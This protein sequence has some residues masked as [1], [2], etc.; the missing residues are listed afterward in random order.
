MLSPG[1]LLLA[2]ACSYQL[3][4]QISEKVASRVCMNRVKNVCHLSHFESHNFVWHCTALI[5]IKC[6][7]LHVNQTMPGHFWG[8]MIADSAF[9]CD[10][11]VFASSGLS[12]LGSLNRT[13]RYF[14]NIQLLAYSNRVVHL[15]KCFVL[16]KH[17]CPFQIFVQAEWARR[18]SSK[19]FDLYSLKMAVSNI[20]TVT[21][22]CKNI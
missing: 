5:H 9:I 20:F 19:Y 7:H 3:H 1:H 2:W 14:F 12:Y 16:R 18:L 6:S 17:A 4:S 15:L 22:I 8:S 13:G 11:L 21:A 10:I